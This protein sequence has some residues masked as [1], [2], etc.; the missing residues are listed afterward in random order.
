MLAKLNGIP[1]ALDR[2]PLGLGSPTPPMEVRDRL[3]EDD[4]SKLMLGVDRERDP[5]GV[6]APSS[7]PK[8]SE[9][10]EIVNETDD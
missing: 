10:I 6:V 5:L 3:A 4:T 7:L 8:L 2:V 9:G 1:V